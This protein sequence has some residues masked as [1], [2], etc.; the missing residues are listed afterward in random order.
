VYVVPV[1][2]IKGLSAPLKLASTKNPG[3]GKPFFDLDDLCTYVVK[4]GASLKVILMS[5]D[6]QPRGDFCMGATLL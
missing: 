1:A 5:K 6:L 2:S 3:T 4:Y